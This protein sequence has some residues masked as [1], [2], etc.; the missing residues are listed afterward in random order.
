MLLGLALVGLN[1]LKAGSEA[2]KRKEALLEWE[3]NYALT[4]RRCGKSAS[5]VN[6]TYNRYECYCGNKFAGAKH[7]GRYGHF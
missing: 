4:C 1:L 7:S 6:G 3:I 5:P 2:Q